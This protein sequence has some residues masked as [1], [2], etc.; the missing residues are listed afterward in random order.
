[1][2]KRQL[3]P[4]KPD[5]GDERAVDRKITAEIAEGWVLANTARHRTPKPRSGTKLLQQT[6]ENCW[7]KKTGPPFGGPEVSVRDYFLLHRI[8]I[9]IN[10]VNLAEI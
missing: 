1:M 2:P 3:Q 10:L 9:G 6:D 8:S 5:R 4:F 7:D